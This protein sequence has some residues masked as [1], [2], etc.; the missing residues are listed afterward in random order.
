MIGEARVVR[1]MRT[2]HVANL[3]HPSYLGRG[4]MLRLMYVNVS[5]PVHRAY[6]LFT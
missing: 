1:N 3:H 6:L 2:S 5:L 4:F